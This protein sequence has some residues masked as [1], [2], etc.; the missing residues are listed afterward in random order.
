MLWYKKK[1]LIISPEW[2]KHNLESKYVDKMKD[3]Y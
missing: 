2:R 3:N 1:V